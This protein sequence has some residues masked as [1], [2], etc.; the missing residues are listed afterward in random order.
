MYDKEIQ[1]LKYKIKGCEK[2]IKAG[3]T[4]IKISA[5][6]IAALIFVATALGVA[7][8]A[9][10]SH[11]ILMG[12]L[13]FC[14]SSLVSSTIYIGGIENSKLYV[15][16]AKLKIDEYNDLI[17]KYKQEE[18]KLLSKEVEKTHEKSYS[19]K[20]GEGRSATKDMED[21]I[22]MFKKMKDDEDHKKKK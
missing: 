21:M 2:T 6:I 13:G 20:R 16:G 11:P 17:N 5:I 9:A 15:D 1:E 14:A 4:T 18:K 19:F 8:G 10:M 7:L 12:I 22:D 3:E